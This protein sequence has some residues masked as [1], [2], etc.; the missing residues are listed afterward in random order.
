MKGFA[1]AA[2]LGGIQLFHGPR[3]LLGGLPAR[4]RR[5]AAPWG[6]FAVGQGSPLQAQNA[7]RGGAGGRVCLWVFLPL[8]TQKSSPASL[9]RG[10]LAT[11]RDCG[12]GK[13]P[14][15]PLISPSLGPTVDFSP[16]SLPLP[17]VPSGLHT[18]T[19]AELPCHIRTWSKCQVSRNTCA[20]SRVA[21]ESHAAEVYVIRGPLAKKRDITTGTCVCVSALLGPRPLPG[22]PSDGQEHLP[23]LGPLLA[24]SHDPCDLFPEHPSRRSLYAHEAKSFI[25]LDQ[26]S[27]FF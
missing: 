12:F 10:A 7:H 24:S 15:L 11:E 18:A 17:P 5:L 6:S 19:Q 20:E 26:L 13:A 27:V 2:G 14:A 3:H 16:L 21:P 25:S 22:V 1:K 4:G 9:L 23:A 8:V